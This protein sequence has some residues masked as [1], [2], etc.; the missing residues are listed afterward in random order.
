[1]CRMNVY[2]VYIQ[3]WIQKSRSAVNFENNVYKYIINFFFAVITAHKQQ[4]K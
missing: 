2:N 3:E 1:M 4:R